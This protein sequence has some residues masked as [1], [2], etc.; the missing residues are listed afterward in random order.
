MLLDV[1]HESLLVDE[2]RDNSVRDVFVAFLRLW[3]PRLFS[4]PRRKCINLVIQLDIAR[5]RSPFVV[6]LRFGLMP[7]NPHRFHWRS[8]F[9]RRGFDET[10]LIGVIWLL[11]GLLNGVCG[12]L[13]V[14]NRRFAVA[15]PSISA[16]RWKMPCSYQ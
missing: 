6:R 9:R 14:R 4:V 5:V 10:E 2:S 1:A 3:V 7:F 12:S 16:F 11:G 13:L 8:E 15:N